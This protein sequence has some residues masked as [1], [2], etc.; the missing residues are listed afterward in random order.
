MTQI[1]PVDDKLQQ[2]KYCFLLGVP[3]NLSLMAYAVIKGGEAV[4]ICQ[5]E[6]SSDVCMIR[7]IAFDKSIVATIIP[8]MLFRS[9]LHFADDC[10]LKRVEVLDKNIPEDILIMSG[11]SPYDNGYYKL[12]LQ[13]FIS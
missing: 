5:F 9:I 10:K 7:N 11:F 6:L 1:L 2:Q 13:N 3:F 12:D 4:G 8:F